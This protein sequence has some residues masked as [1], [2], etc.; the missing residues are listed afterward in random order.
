MCLWTCKAQVVC[1]NLLQCVYEWV[2]S[3]R[4]HCR[5]NACWPD[6]PDSPHQT[7]QP[8]LCTGA[9]LQIHNR[10]YSNT[11]TH[12]HTQ[13]Q[14]IPLWHKIQLNYIIAHEQDQSFLRTR[15][16]PQLFLSSPL[17]VEMLATAITISDRE[18]ESKLC[19]HFS[20]KSLGNS[21]SDNCQQCH[22]KSRT[23]TFQGHIP[24]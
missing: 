15:V 10:Q 17:R 18:P 12:T 6:Y 16:M 5:G 14:N 13:I 24:N 9:A 20:S 8:L 4:V 3:A 23:R 21:E 11:N 1:C 19:L 2:V 22:T 7:K